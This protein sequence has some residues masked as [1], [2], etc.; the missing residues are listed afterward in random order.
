M[1][2]AARSY[3][4]DLAKGRRAERS[5]AVQWALEQ[6]L[7]PVVLSPATAEDDYTNGI[8]LWAETLDGRRI[9]VQVKARHA[10]YNG[11]IIIELVANTA[12]ERPGWTLTTKARLLVIV[13]Y[14]GGRVDHVAVLSA[15][16]LR[17]W[18]KIRRRALAARAH[19]TRTR[20]GTYEYK[21]TFTPVPLN[22]LPRKLVL[23]PPTRPPETATTRG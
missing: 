8:D 18:A 17:V 4:L 13:W 14:D 10:P 19:T 15:L 21:S 5:P 22:E 1:P 2:R 20:K 23:L 9:P 12:T 7:G 3:T 16:L 11:D 6:V